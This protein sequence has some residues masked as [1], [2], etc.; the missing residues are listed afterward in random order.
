MIYNSDQFFR[1]PVRF[2][3]YRYLYLSLVGYKWS[4]L[5]TFLSLALFALFPAIPSLVVARGWSS[6]LRCN[7]VKGLFWHSFDS[8]LL[9]R[10]NRCALGTFLSQG[11]QSRGKRCSLRLAV[12]VAPRG[13]NTQK[14][15]DKFFTIKL[16]VCVKRKIRNVRIARL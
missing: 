3:Q 11:F 15:I 9:N 14:A 8:A 12:A 2:Y 16:C 1:S 13:S 7:V 10:H 6:T 4:S 5:L